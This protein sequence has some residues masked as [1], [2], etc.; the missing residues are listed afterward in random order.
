ML[1][2]QQRNLLRCDDLRVSSAGARSRQCGVSRFPRIEFS[3]RS[4][5]LPRWPYQSQSK[6]CLARRRRKGV[7][8][9]SFG[10]GADPGHHEHRG[11]RTSVP[12]E[13]SGCRSTVGSKPLDQMIR[14]FF[15]SRRTWSSHFLRSS[16]ACHSACANG[17]ASGFFS[18]AIW[19]AWIDRAATS[20]AALDRL[21][22]RGCA[23][24][25]LLARGR[26]L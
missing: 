7:S 18:S 9:S 4:V 3:A 17:C 8:P 6:V 19:T 25:G 12:T 15:F 24:I 2:A 10:I 26:G 5:L 23:T 11:P 21:F 20:P 13:A 22:T 14:P 16:F 1:R